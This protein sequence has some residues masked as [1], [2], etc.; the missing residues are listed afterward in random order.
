MTERC[1]RVEIYTECEPFQMK[2][3]REALDDLGDKYFDDWTF[4]VMDAS[5]DEELEYGKE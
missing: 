4:F 1:Y 2:G 3:F 5:T